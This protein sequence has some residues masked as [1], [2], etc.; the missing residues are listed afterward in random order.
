[1]LAAPTEKLRFVLVHG[2]FARNAKW[3]RFD[4][5]LSRNL[6]LRFPGST[7]NVF[8]WSGRNSISA[9]HQASLDLQD[10]LSGLHE[11][12]PG[13]HIV[14]IAH[15]HGG[16]L[17]LQAASSPKTAGM[18]SGICCLSTPFISPRPRRSD[19]VY[20]SKTPVGAS[21]FMGGLL[22]VGAWLLLKHISGDQSWL[23]WIALF[24]GAAGGA[25]F[26]WVLQSHWYEELIGALTE[27]ITLPEVKPCTV[28][29]LR[30]FADEPMAASA[31]CWRGLVASSMR[32]NRGKPIG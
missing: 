22:A 23:L 30:S 27:K 26:Y 9:R 6:R 5:P 32:K 28:L 31:V 11:R 7:I 3:T 18:C 20:F 29:I 13:T 1:M 14:L 12:C 17:S 25:P 19:A 2:T 8:G 10:H 15:S 4:S 21:A 24:I 16:T